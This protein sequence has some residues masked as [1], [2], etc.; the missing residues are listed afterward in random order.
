MF[1]FAVEH[2]TACLAI[3]CHGQQERRSLGDFRR[4]AKFEL[5]NQLAVRFARSSFEYLTGVKPV[6]KDVERHVMKN[7]QATVPCRDRL[8]VSGPV[9]RQSAPAR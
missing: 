1:R 7:S 5:S 2:R 6:D 9:G 3:I 4:H 8:L